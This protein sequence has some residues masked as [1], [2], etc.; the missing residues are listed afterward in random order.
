MN[1][2]ATILPICLQYLQIDGDDITPDNRDSLY[3]YGNMG[4][5]EHLVL[6]LSLRSVR[7]RITILPELPV[8]GRDKNT[9]AAI[10]Q[11]RIED[12]YFAK[13]KT[14]INWFL[15][16]GLGR[17]SEH[18]HDMLPLLREAFPDD[19]FFCLDQP[20]CGPR[21]Q[22]PSPMSITKTVEVVR[23]DYLALQQKGE[24][25]Q[26]PCYFLSLSL[27]GM[28]A[29]V[30]GQQYA[31]EFQGAVLINT[32]LPGINRFYDRLRPSNLFAMIAPRRLDRIETRERK[33]ME[34]G[35]QR[36]CR[37]STP[38]AEL[39]EHSTASP[40]DRTQL[41]LYAALGDIVHGTLAFAVCTYIGL[42]IT[43]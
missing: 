41:H 18:W 34:L 38:V 14:D 10:A 30:W 19:C 31:N 11:Q 43:A 26:R 42:E 4:F 13:T 1:E 27:G 32:S 36:S 8:D 2:N 22:E 21:W 24:L 3:W 29:V 40:C 16:R 12:F 5:F 7:A 9:L 39:G 15:L 28:I 37:A 17:E 23:G 6:I 25:G 33:I 35:Q 20:G